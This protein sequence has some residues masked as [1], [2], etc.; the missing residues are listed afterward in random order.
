MPLEYAKPEDMP[1]VRKRRRPP[2][3]QQGTDMASGDPEV[4]T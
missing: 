1:H 2:I 3:K 4:L